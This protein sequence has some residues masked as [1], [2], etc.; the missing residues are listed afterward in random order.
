[1]RIEWL[2][3]QGFGSYAKYQELNF[4][5]ALQFEQMFI[6]SGKTGAG[7]TMI[8]DAIH[9]ALYGQASGADRNERTLCS[10]FI[11]SGIKPYV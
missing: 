11:D 8:F 7:K 1:M 10:D 2:K 9:Y 6:I 3:M 5:H 4:T